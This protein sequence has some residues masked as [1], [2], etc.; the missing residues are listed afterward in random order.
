MSEHPALAYT[1]EFYAT[2]LTGF[3]RDV[4]GGPAVVVASGGAANVAARAASNNPALSS[5]W[6]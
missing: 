3:L 5:A 6:R 1:G 4:V 2:I